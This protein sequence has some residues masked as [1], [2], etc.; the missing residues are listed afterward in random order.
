MRPAD[1]AKGMRGAVE[2]CKELA[3]KTPNSFILQQFDNPANP[4]I[5]RRTTG[6]G[7]AP[8]SP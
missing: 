3:A 1:P 2:A 5:H 4:D 6:E 7:A 8:P